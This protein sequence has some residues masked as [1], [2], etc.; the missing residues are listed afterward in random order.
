MNSDLQRIQN[1][2]QAGIAAAKS[3]DELKA[4]E[5]KYLGKKGELVGLLRG[6]GSMPAEERPKFGAATNQVKT[7]LEALLQEKL[8]KLE[9]EALAKSSSGSAIDI[10][11]P[12]IKFPTGHLH[13]LTQIQHELEDIFSSMGFSIFDG[14]EVEL[15]Y[16][17]FDAL[18]IPADHPARDMQD[19]FWCSN[20]AR[21]NP[22]F[23][24]RLLM[25][26]HTS[27]V[28][29]R[30]M[31]RWLKEK[32]P[33]PLRAIVPGRVFRNEAVDASHE[34]TFWQ[35]E[36]LVVGENINVAHL[37]GTLR[38]F[39]RALFGKDLE[40]RLRPGYFPFVEPGFEMDARCPFCT[41]GC[42]VCKRSTWIE[43][44]PSG[45][46]H[47]NV[48]KAGGF[49]PEK[50]SGFAFG[51]GLSRL[52]ML[53]YGIQDIRLFLGNDLRFLEQF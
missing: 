8:A 7:Q 33:L 25:R 49:D 30:G 28:Q 36:G 41:N 26:T 52:A 38:S 10:T 18:N 19:T 16:Y 11:E 22:S 51:L 32:R 1:D 27:P 42:S 20:P 29:V 43:L 34:H 14:P 9:D 40:I 2:A 53:R 47:P 13:P 37:M 23:S 24:N 5:N 4:I 48:L 35:M 50:Y 31:E 15:E 45:I 17:N 46:V 21:M 6:L 39:L 12:G 44:V 3:L